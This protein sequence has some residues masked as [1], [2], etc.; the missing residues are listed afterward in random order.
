[1]Q[2]AMLGGAEAPPSMVPEPI[3]IGGRY[4]FEATLLKVF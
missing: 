3:E 4:S 1:M 2:D